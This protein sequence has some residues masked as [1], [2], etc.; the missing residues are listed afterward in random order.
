METVVN[1]MMTLYGKQH[2]RLTVFCSI[3]ANC[4]NRQKIVVIREDIQIECREIQLRNTGNI[5]R[6][7]VLRKKNAACKL[8]GIVQTGMI[9]PVEASVILYP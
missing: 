3:L 6:Q 1:R 7:I 2:E 8:C 4:E 9:K 5:G